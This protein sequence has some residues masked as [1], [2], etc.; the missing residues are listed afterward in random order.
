MNYFGSIRWLQRGNSDWYQVEVG[1]LDPSLTNS[2][3]VFVVNDWILKDYVRY[4]SKA[5]VISTDDPGYD[6]AVAQKLMRD[7]LSKNHKVI[8]YNSHA[9]WYWHAI[10]SD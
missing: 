3:I 1:K 8:V 7:A 10:Q 5:K 9:G 4:Y 2:D 6:Q